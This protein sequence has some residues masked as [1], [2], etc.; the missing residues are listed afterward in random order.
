MD[1]DKGGPCLSLDNTV[2]VDNCAVVVVMW[3]GED[4]SGADSQ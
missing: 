3:G 4:S 1:V 2:V